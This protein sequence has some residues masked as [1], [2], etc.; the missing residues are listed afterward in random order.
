ML[1]R[2]AL[3]FLSGAASHSYQHIIMTIAITYYH[4]H[5]Y[6]SLIISIIIINIISVTV[7]LLI[8]SVAYHR[9]SFPLLVVMPKC[10]KYMSVIV[11]VILPSYC[12]LPYRSLQRYIG[13][14]IQYYPYCRRHCN[15]WLTIIA[16]LPLVVTI[17]EC[18]SDVIAVEYYLIPIIAIMILAI[19]WYLILLLSLPLPIISH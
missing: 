6:S 11:A 16:I 2:L 9:L 4:H 18:Y 7:L 13:A 3:T 19:S 5:W 10:A 1:L 12:Y 15:Y 14:I 17:T 8:S